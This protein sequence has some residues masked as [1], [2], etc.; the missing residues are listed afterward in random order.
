MS[1]PA[2][3]RPATVEKGDK[4]PLRSVLAVL[5]EPFWIR[6]TIAVVVLCV[7]FFYLG[8][9]QLHRHQGKV[10]RNQLIN[11]N[12]AGIPV[13]L[14]DV[15]ATPSTPL[16][17]DRQWTQVRVSGVYEAAHQVLI[18]NR[19]L[20]GDFGFEVVVPLRTASG[21]ALLV[22]RGWVPPGE[23]FV[24]PDV[25]PPPPAGE[26]TVVVRL[27]PAE[28]PLDQAPPPGQEYRIDPD[29]LA[30]T[31]GGTLYRGA[32]G[33]LATETPAP[34]RAPQPLP[35]P[36]ED[37]GPHLAYAIQWW[38]ADVAAVVLLLVYARR[39]AAGRTATPSGPQPPAG[40]ERRFAR[41]RSGPT[42]EEWEDAASG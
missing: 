16:P 10:A 2:P 39:D 19:P 7:A 15:L 22:D 5:R 42:D 24:A 8:R 27:R 20:E 12:Y 21:A 23:K 1:S 38:F 34:A 33:V 36:D 6:V 40:G 11:A 9:W 25:V 26:V 14:E 3:L 35:R 18:R 37:L 28:P 30:A 29:R 17:A 31:V 32:Y 4:V 41:R 13:P